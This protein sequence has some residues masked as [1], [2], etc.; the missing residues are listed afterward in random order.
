MR[1]TGQATQGVPGRRGAPAHRQTQRQSRL[2]AA[3]WHSTRARRRRGGPAR[4]P[5]TALARPVAP[6]AVP[7]WQCLLPP[8]AGA[9]AP[10]LPAWARPTRSLK[11]GRAM[12]AAQL[13]YVREQVDKARRREVV[14]AQRER[15][16]LAAAALAVQGVRHGI[17]ARDAT[18]PC[19]RTRSA[20]TRRRLPPLGAARHLVL[21]R[22]RRRRHRRRRNAPLTR[23]SA[24]PR[25]ARLGTLPAPQRAQRRPRRPRRRVHRAHQTLDGGWQRPHGARGGQGGV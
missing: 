2:R 22:R 3:G 15:C 14:L 6:V 12:Q 13:P 7:P 5:A 20:Q 9:Q 19:R 23:R 8:W 17:A 10:R 4:R 1:P 11:R 18:Q 25:R 24:A 21:G 16:R